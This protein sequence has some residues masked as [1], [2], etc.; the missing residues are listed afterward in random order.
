MQT[1]IFKKDISNIILYDFLDS[2]CVLENN[3]YILDRESYKKY[4]FNN[5]ISDF[6][7]TMEQ[8]YKKNKKYYIEREYSYNNLLTIIRQICR[9]NN[10][11]YINKIKY[12]KSKYNIIYYILKL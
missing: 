6:Y 2:H 3:Y 4:E 10:I 12:N 8:Y 11:V 1:T 9:K 5:Q 7:K